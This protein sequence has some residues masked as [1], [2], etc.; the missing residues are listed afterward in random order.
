MA[1]HLLLFF[2]YSL[3]IQII[4][5]AFSL[6]SVHETFVGFNGGKDCTVLFNLVYCY[7]LYNNIKHPLTLVYFKDKYSFP[8]LD[9]FIDQIK[10]R[11]FL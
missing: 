9:Q 11:Y 3:F 2:F 4:S 7:C 10:D 6:F 8:E 1:M 5:K